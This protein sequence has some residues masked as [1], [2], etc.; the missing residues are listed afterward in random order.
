MPWAI[1][2]AA[3]GAPGCTNPGP[4]NIFDSPFRFI[5]LSRHG[6]STTAFT[7]ERSKSVAWVGVINSADSAFDRCDDL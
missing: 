5:L 6:I 4:G 2:T 7:N 3:T 1:A